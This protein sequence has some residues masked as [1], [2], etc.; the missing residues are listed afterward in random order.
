MSQHPANLIF[1]FFLEMVSLYAIGQWGWRQAGDAWRWGLAIGLPLIAAAVWGIFKV[2]GD[3]EVSGKVVVPVSGWLRLGI[4]FIFFG[5]AVAALLSTGQLLL[6]VLVLV[7]IFLHYL[8]SMDRL[9]HL[10]Q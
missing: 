2:Q 4:E 6:G 5:L 9:R 1:R 7:A 3:Q 8:L 10:L